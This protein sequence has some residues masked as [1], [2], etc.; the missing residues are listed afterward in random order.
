MNEIRS[1]AAQAGVCDEQRLLMDVLSR[2]TVAHSVDDCFDV[3][4]QL[5]TPVYRSLGQDTIEDLERGVL[6]CV[7]RIAK[8]RR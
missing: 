1:A 7:E 6:I 2:L 5:V 3:W 4:R 8:P